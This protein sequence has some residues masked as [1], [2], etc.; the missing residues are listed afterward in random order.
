MGNNYTFFFMAFSFLNILS[1]LHVT[2]C[3]WFL[4]SYLSIDFLISFSC[5]R[6]MIFSVGSEHCQILLFLEL[7][8][9]HLRESPGELG[10]DIMARHWAVTDFPLAVEQC[11]LLL[12]ALISCLYQSKI[13]DNCLLCGFSFNLLRLSSTFLYSQQTDILL[14]WFKCNC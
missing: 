4:N 9:C 12:T 7:L 14:K 10:A 3:K 5:S 8:L 2:N 1:I 6:V 13:N 11:F